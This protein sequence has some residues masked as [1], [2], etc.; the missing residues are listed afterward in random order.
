M[1]MRKR[2]SE[3]GIALPT[4][5]AAAVVVSIL[6]AVVLN[7]TFRRFELSVSRTSRAE[8]SLAAETGLQYAFERLR[9][10]PTFET[11]VRAKAPDFYV[12][13]SSTS[14][15]VPVQINGVSTSYPVDEGPIPELAFGNRHVHIAI[16]EDP[17]DP[18]IPPILPRLEIHT[19]A[20]TGG[21]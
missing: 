7:L 8:A 21:P 5:I 1:A 10:D 20:E 12:I 6:A 2:C 11:N 15:F 13:T 4:A 14:L 9:S 17:V 3:R 18:P 16:R 19:N